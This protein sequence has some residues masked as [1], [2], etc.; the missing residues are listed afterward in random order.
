MSNIYIAYVGWS[1]TPSGGSWSGSLPLTNLFVDDLSKVAR[2]TNANLTSTK[3]DID[4]GVTHTVNS[5]IL[6]PTN[7]SS[8]YLVRVRGAPT[9]A[10]A[11]GY[12]SGWIDPTLASTDIDSD[13]GTNVVVMFPSSQSYQ[14]WRIELD[15]TGNSDGYVQAGRLFLTRTRWQAS[16]NFAPGSNG[17]SWEDRTLRGET[18]G[19]NEKQTRRRNRRV[20]NFQ[21]PFIDEDE[22][23]GAFHR[24]QRDA[25]FDDLVFLIPDPEA[26]DA[27]MATRAF[28]GRIGQMD[29]ITQSAFERAGIGLTIREV[30]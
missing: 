21:I 3:F 28:W 12:D 22:A 18:W 8:A 15:D 16:V 9:N 27:I 4:L 30:F 19:G 10:F 6:G 5:M 20:F 2:S 23:F 14:Y 17:L 26:T 29:P 24:L 13:R 7:L 11:S 25:G 1:G